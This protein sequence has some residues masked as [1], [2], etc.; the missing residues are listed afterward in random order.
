VPFLGLGIG[1]G[2]N[3]ASVLLTGQR[4]LFSSEGEWGKTEWRIGIYNW[5]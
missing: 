5:G 1:L 2:T 3:V 4:S